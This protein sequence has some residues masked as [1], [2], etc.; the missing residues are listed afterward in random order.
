VRPAWKGPRAARLPGARACAHTFSATCGD[1]GARTPSPLTH[2]L[3]SLSHSHPTARTLTADKAAPATTAAGA[4]VAEPIPATAAAATNTA[5]AV[6]KEVTAAPAD[7]A[8]QLAQA[9]ADALSAPVVAGRQVNAPTT[10]P[11]AA[12]PGLAV[13][14]PKF[15]A[16]PQLGLPELPAV[17]L[18]V[19]PAALA[20]TIPRVQF[21]AKQAAGEG[22]AAAAP[23][24]PLMDAAASPAGAPVQEL[25]AVDEAA[26]ATQRRG[27][28]KPPPLFPPKP[29]APKAPT[30]RPPKAGRGAG[31]DEEVDGAAP[32]HRAPARERAPHGDHPSPA[33]V[34]GEGR[35]ANNA[36]GGA[37]RLLAGAAKAKDEALVAP[38]AGPI[39][40]LPRLE[41][42]MGG[43]ASFFS[44]PFFLRG[45]WR[46]RA[47]SN[48]SLSL[49]HRRSHISSL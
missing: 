30:H 10:G 39:L 45:G 12:A 29:A 28:P 16:V 38:N 42:P 31:G 44:F 43:S 23:Q 17:N 1:S 6:G 19:N 15:G 13:P 49:S 48:L 41:I 36:N 2:S 3:L 11:A 35:W 47:P 9:T 33:E 22:A 40:T 27:P 25:A 34:F 26:P 5:K 21:V 18:N 20:A 14:L 4:V 8:A 7:A 32:A 24:Q 46:S 37:R